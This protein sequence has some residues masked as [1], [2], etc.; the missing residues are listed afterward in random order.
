M[1]WLI[2]LLIAFFA[3]AHATVTD[4]ATATSEPAPPSQ[5]Q[6]DSIAQRFAER[7]PYPSCGEATAGFE[8]DWDSVGRDEW[9]CLVDALEEGR[10][11]E[12][13]FTFPTVEGD[14][15][16]EFYR[17]TRDGQLEYFS[18]NTDDAFRG[19]DWYYR[20]CT[21]GPRFPERRPPGARC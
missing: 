18:D 7:E 5:A 12:L 11:A 21:P 1:D 17:I 2:W 4:S 20:A 16:R 9:R 3:P 19:K 8:D 13:M 15:I 10:S 6:P 14:P